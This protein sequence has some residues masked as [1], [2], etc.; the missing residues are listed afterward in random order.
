MAETT[1]S[2]ILRLHLH[3]QL[4][5]RHRSRYAPELLAALAGSGVAEHLGRLLLVLLPAIDT[6]PAMAPQGAIV[7]GMPVMPS[8]LAT[9]FLKATFRCALH[10]MCGAEQQSSYPQRYEFCADNLNGGLRAGGRREGPLA[11]LSRRCS[12]P[13]GP[14]HVAAP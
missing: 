9:G 3:P 6:C 10:S 5:H 11:C 7:F 4:R 8:E 12:W 14:R 1:P 2:P 13:V